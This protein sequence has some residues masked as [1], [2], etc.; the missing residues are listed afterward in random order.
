MKKNA[1]ICLI[2]IAV[3][4][5][6]YWPS[7][8]YDF[9]YLDEEYLILNRQA[10]LKDPTNVG[11]VFL[12]GA[13]YPSK[14]SSFYR[15]I[16]TLSFMVDA[17]LGDANPVPYHTTNIF[18]HIGAALLAFV[19]IGELGFSKLLSALF[20]LIFVSHP[21]LTQAVS[22]V[23]G[24]NDSL[25]AIF[26]FASI[27]LFLRA[28]HAGSSRWWY[29]AHLAAF[30][31]ALFTKEV[32][33]VIPVVCM[34]FRWVYPAPQRSRHWWLL[35]IGW[36]ALLIAWFLFRH[37]ALANAE[38]PVF[39]AGLFIRTAIPATMLYLGKMLIPVKLSVMPYLPDTSLWVSAVAVLVLIA[40][41][42][43]GVDR[44]NRRLAIAGLLWM[45]LWLGPS[46]ISVEPANRT[47][48][49][50]HRAYLPLF[51]FL[52]IIFIILRRLLSSMKTSHMGVILGAIVVIFGG[53]ARAHEP[54]FQNGISF[55]KSAIASAPNLSRSY[56][57]LAVIFSREGN[58]Q[59][60]ISNH[61]RAI[62]LGPTNKQLHN[63]LGVTYTRMGRFAD[64]ET[65]LLQE[66]AINPRFAGAY[67]NLSAVYAL[68]NK[69]LEAQEMYKKYEALN[70][71]EL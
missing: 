35:G 52:L 68:E 53:V 11:D 6:L 21:I 27:Y 45:I 55:W 18:L 57:G 43:W 40:G 54:V 67:K 62:E 66:I 10:Y 32:A 50:E 49:L 22:W 9:V 8:S 30:A 2:I 5:A 26:A 61:L 47:V 58:Y 34:I 36:T 63:N 17:E 42:I 59:G 51:G 19:L 70:F 1:L 38:L 7:R 28:S 48:F 64:A 46:L 3:G 69:K 13:M 33:I 56:D 14:L 39:D 25:L 12:Q 41:F 37:F 71:G 29:V 20:V 23:P 24:R 60:A 31:L 15:P 65:A 4:L 16:L 44:N